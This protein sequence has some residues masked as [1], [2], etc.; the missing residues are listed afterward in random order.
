M[1][2][3]THS[4]TTTKKQK[5][6]KL[7]PLNIYKVLN[8]FVY[9]HMYAY[10]GNHLFICLNERMNDDCHNEW[11]NEWGVTIKYFATTIIS[12]NENNCQWL[13]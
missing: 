1:P 7:M 3:D 13:W 9:V 12:W 10:V 4:T 11:I 8:V 2:K 6:T 5:K